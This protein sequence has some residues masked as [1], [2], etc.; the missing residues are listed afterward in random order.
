MKKIFAGGL[1]RD[2]TDD[3]LKGHF[4]QY[5]EITDSVIIADKT[6][7]VSKGFGFITYQEVSSVEACFAARPH[8][9]DGK[10]V[11]VKRA[12]PKSDNSKTRDV[13]TKRVFV[14]GVAQETTADEI[15]AYIDKRHPKD[16]GCGEAEDVDILKDGT[17]GKNRGFGFV[18]CSNEDFADRLAIC[19]DKF[20]LNG[21][22]MSMQ[23][24]QPKDN[25]G[26][27]FT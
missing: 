27:Y 15:K 16:L 19:E 14:G 2:T 5:G 13:R 7:N 20:E 10:T 1:S 11:D 23:K 21:K 17:T 6:T 8:N 12:M 4:S 26:I 24:A 9:I 22:A 3:T 18:N 25:E